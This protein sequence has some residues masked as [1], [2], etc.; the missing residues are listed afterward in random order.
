MSKPENK[1]FCSTAIRIKK[2]NK[3]SFRLT[4]TVAVLLSIENQMLQATVTVKRKSQAALGLA[5]C[6]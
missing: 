5:F 3:N 6:R 1:S 2:E 4:V